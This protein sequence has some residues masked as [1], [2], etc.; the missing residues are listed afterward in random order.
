MADKVSKNSRVVRRN[1]TATTSQKKK[2][3]THFLIPRKPGK[4]VKHC[5]EY[6]SKE[7]AE[8]AKK[9]FPFPTSVVEKIK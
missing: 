9:N 8:T 4:P 6:S 2:D 1:N 5:G 7:E 3:I